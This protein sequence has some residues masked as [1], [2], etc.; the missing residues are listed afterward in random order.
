LADLMAQIGLTHGGFYRQFES[1][2]ALI[3][4]ATVKAF[5]DLSIPVT[6]PPRG[7]R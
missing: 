2:Q 6:T 7:W 3:A 4:E 1:K 5:G